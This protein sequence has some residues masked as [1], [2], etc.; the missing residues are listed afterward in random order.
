LP[1]ALN[2]NPMISAELTKYR[3]T[4]C[5]RA[6]QRDQLAQHARRMRRGQRETR[7][8]TESGRL[9]GVLTRHALAVLS[10]RSPRTAR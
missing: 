1:A 3:I 6:A 7:S 4:D 10:A 8:Q 9:A 2:M 5:R